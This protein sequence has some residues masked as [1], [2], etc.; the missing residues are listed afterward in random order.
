MTEVLPL[1]FKQCQS[2]TLKLGN[3]PSTSLVLNQCQFPLYSHYVSLTLY[4]LWMGEVIPQYSHTVDL[5]QY[6]LEM[7][8]VLPLYSREVSLTQYS[9]GMTKVLPLYSHNV[10]LTRCHFSERYVGAVGRSYNMT[11]MPSLYKL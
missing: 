7:I 2:P 1:I 6:S 3:D 8:E 9:L 5:T 4:S 11:T 10:S